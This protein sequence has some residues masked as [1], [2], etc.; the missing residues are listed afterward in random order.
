MKKLI[1]FFAAVLLCQAL[2]AQNEIVTT[3]APKGRFFPSSGLSYLDDPARYFSIQMINTTGT[4]MDIFFTIDLS[5]DFSINNENYYLRT[6]KEIQPASPLAVGASPVLINRTIFDQIIG[7]LNSSAY[8]TNYDLNNPS[9]NMLT[10]P[11][12]QYRFC[13]TPY[14][15]DG[16]NN[17]NPTKVGETVCYTFYICYTGSA[18]EFTTPVNGLSAGNFNNSNPTNNLLNQNAN[19]ALPTSDNRQ[20]SQYARLPLTRTVVFNWTGVISNCLT[21]NDFDYNLKIVEVALNQNVQD[22]IN[23]NGTLNTVTIK[24]KTNYIHDTVANRNFRFIPGHV[25]A[26]QVQ[27]VPKK[28]LVTDIQLSNEGKSQIITFVWGDNVPITQP[29]SSGS[30]LT[31]SDADNKDQVLKNIRNPYFL[32]P[33][34]DKAAIENLTSLIS[35]ESANIPA[36]NGNAYVTNVT[37]NDVPYYQVKKADSLTVNWMPVRGDSVIRVQYTAELYEYSGGP[38]SENLIG[39]PLKTKSFEVTTPTSF[40]PQ[41]TTPTSIATKDWAD[42]LEEGFKYLIHLKAKTDYSYAKTTTFTFTEYIHDMPVTHDSVTSTVMFGN[43]EYTSDVVFAWGI[44]SGALDKVYPPQFSYPVDLTTKPWNDSVWSDLPEVVKHEDFSFKWKAAKGVNYGDSVY[45]KLLVAKLPVGKKPQMVKD[46][47]FF[48]DSI[49]DLTYI[50]STLFDSLKTGGQYMAVLWAYVKQIGDT[51]SHYNILNGGKSLYA[52]FKLKDPAKF[53]ADLSNKIKCSPKALE[54]LSKDVITPK[55]D[56]LIQNQTRLKM[57]DFPLVIQTGKF[58][59]QK[60]TYTGDGYVVWKPFGIDVRLKV[61]FDSIQINKNN[62]IIK[63]TAAST[64]TDSSTYLSA[65]VN[66]LNLDEWTND[67]VTRA[68]G[69]L[70]EIDAVK[71]YYDKF[72]EYGEKYAKKYGGLLGPLMGGNI[73]TEVLTFPLSITDE[74]LTGSKNVIFAINNMFFSPETALMGLWAI[75]AAQDDDYYVPFLANNICMDQEGFLGKSSQHI[76]MFMG[77]T[78]EKELNDGYVLRFKASSNFADPKDGTVI[79]IDDGKLNYIRAEIQMDM[80]NDDLLGID[81]KTGTPQKGKIVQ[82]TLDVKFSDWSDWVVKVN[83]DPFAVTGSDRYVFVPTGKG[84]YYD[85]SA[86]ETP[87]VVTLPYEY[88]FGTPPPADLKDE[89]KK[90]L[91]KATKEWQGF[92]WDELSVVL[93]DEISNTF[94][95]NDTIK[96]DS[97][98]V[99]RYGINNTVVDSV[100]FSFPGRRISFGAK[101]VIIDKF[102]FSA[103]IYAHDLLRAETTKG[104]GWAFSLDTINVRFTKNK[105]KEGLIKGGFGVPLFSGGFKYSCSIGSDSLMFGISASKNPLDL[106][107]WAATVKFDSASSYFRI[108]KKYNESGTRIDL[109]MNGKISISGSKI[110]L[111]DFNAVKFE[112]MGMRNYNLSGKPKEGT[113]SIKGFEFDIGHW[114]FASPQKYIGGSHA[115]EQATADGEKPIGSVSIAG[116]TFSVTKFD[117]INES[118]GD[119]LK[120]GLTVKGKMK[121]GGDGGNEESA[122]GAG[123]GFSF[124]GVVQP[125]NK[126][127]VKEVKGKLESIELEDID[128][129]VFKMSGK[130]DFTYACPTCTDVT[131]FAGDLSIKVMSVVELSMRAGFGKEKSGNSEYSW[132][133]FDGACK[134]TPGIPLGAVSIN[135]F[136]GGFAWNMKAKKDLSDASYSAKALLTKAESNTD[137]ETTK[138]SGMDFTPAKNNWV[139]NAGISM[140]LTGAENT[141]NLDG[142]VSLRIGNGHFSGLF[143]EANAYVLTKVVPG[144]VPG[145]DSHNNKPLIKATTILGYERD[146]ERDYFR[147]SIAALA[148]MDLSKLLDGLSTSAVSEKIVGAIHSGTSL[149]PNSNIES[150]VKKLLD[151]SVNKDMEA[152]KSSSTPG[153]GMKVLIP[154]DFELTH[155]KKAKDGHKAGSTAWYFSIGKPDYDDRLLVEQKLDAVVFKS[156]SKFTFY[157]MTGNSF[158]FKFPELTPEL[159]TFFYGSQKDKKM[160]AS[161]SE[162]TSSRTLSMTDKLAVQNGGGFCMGA[163]FHA[164]TGFNCFLYADVTTDLGFDVALLNVGGVGCPGH[165]QIGK[166]NYYAIGQAYAALQGDV[167]LSLNLG[168]WKGKIS[169]FKAGVGA[170]L[171]AGGPNPSYCYGLLRFQVSMLNGLVKFNTSVDISLGDV[172]VPGAGDPLANVKLFQNVTPG[173]STESIAN[174]KSNIQ[175]P[176]QI[177]I[178]VS[179]MPWDRDVYL[180]DKD[181]KNGRTFRFV[182]VESNCHYYTKPN[183]SYIETQGTEKITFS[184]SRSD[185]NAIL[186]ETDEGGFVESTSNKLVLQARAFERRTPLYSTS[187]KPITFSNGQGKDVSYNVTGNEKGTILSKTP[188]SGKYGWFDPWWEDDNGKITVKRYKV[189]TTLYFKT[190]ALGYSLD[191]GVVFSWPYNGEKQFFCKEYVHSSGSS[192]TPYANMYLYKN[193]DNVFDKTKLGNAGKEMKIFLLRVGEEDNDVD[194]CAYSYSTSGSLPLVKVTLPKKEYT[195]GVGPRKLRFYIVDKNKYKAAQAA[196]EQSMSITQKNAEVQSRISN[197]TYTQAENAHKKNQ[198][199]NTIN[200]QNQQLEEIYDSKHSDGKDSMTF[201]RIKMKSDYKICANNG[202][203]VYEWTW[204]VNGNDDCNGD[205]IRRHFSSSGKNTDNSINYLGEAMRGTKQSPYSD[206]MKLSRQK[207]ANSNSPM[208]FHGWVFNYY[209]PDD[210][211]RYHSGCKLPPLAY[212]V[213]NRDANTPL[214]QLHKRY[215]QHFV[216]M[217]SDFKK[218]PLK[219]TRYCNSSG[220]YKY[221]SKGT[222]TVSDYGL[223]TELSNILKAGLYKNTNTYFD[224]IDRRIKGGTD[225]TQCTKAGYEPTSWDVPCILGI[226][227]GGSRKPMED[228]WFGGE[229]AGR[230]ML[231]RDEYYGWVIYDYASHAI[232]HDIRMIHDFMQSNQ[233]HAEAFNCRGW[234]HKVDFFKKYYSSSGK[235]LKFVY[236]NAANVAFP[237]DMPEI[238]LVTHYMWALDDLKGEKSYSTANGTTLTLYDKNHEFINVSDLQQKDRYWAKYWWNSAGQCLDY[239]DNGFDRDFYWDTKDKYYNVK[240][241]QANKGKQSVSVSNSSIWGDWYTTDWSNKFGKNITNYFHVYYISSQS[242]NFE[243]NLMKIAVAVKKGSSGADNTLIFYPNAII[244][245]DKCYYNIPNKNDNTPVPGTISTCG[246][247]YPGKPNGNTYGLR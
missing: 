192:P 149:I 247:L 121:F 234:S 48:K 5:C 144:S 62:E 239:S 157:L 37:G 83:M 153:F 235:N 112:H 15:W 195:S 242:S 64:A 236:G 122:F 225:F 66:D 126:Y 74:E 204:F 103:D 193:R 166:H 70:G 194:E 150:K 222:T 92:Y 172:C 125:K 143:V 12:G 40:S 163:T 165:P 136:S 113:A 137:Q 91:G 237:Y 186:F 184:G 57:G 2:W 199:S 86:K 124:W 146:K 27:A 185:E 50:D 110:G 41:N 44:D 61:H 55:V 135:G 99:Y 138:S 20:S 101:G 88:L 111:S 168:F 25:Y 17:P 52:T 182:L 223:R 23:Q 191:D 224:F 142:L 38:V 89:D 33:G 16:Y 19:G 8:E 227:Y 207:D 215:F 208:D 71:G 220:K 119:D 116:F 76:D 93:S 106:D 3:I 188:T 164:E 115:D 205:Y 158:S 24:G 174:S 58:D 120:L 190:K 147:L 63:G 206:F 219:T 82:A 14:R 42:T 152:A 100:H 210:S 69:Y 228:K 75:F 214:L 30:S 177:G 87:P 139:A 131:G 104:W 72:K 129:H 200:I 73:A 68:M 198:N 36:D 67:D 46:T 81:A 32:N 7:H 202:E 118:I 211:K 34:K 56:E 229:Y 97:M 107:L 155:Y 183:K 53:E 156:N 181:G 233:M 187:K 108:H 43:Q 148:D 45:Y 11:E 1:S 175:S 179:N 18:P 161:K 26:A 203:L 170:L 231:S 60:K 79:S 21:V 90:K 221:D 98:V 31:S 94:L 51:S 201:Y 178:I 173:F 77:R 232:V 209:E 130:L 169:L 171:Q 160:D 189:D 47:L 80:S 244:K 105:Y 127:K 243:N 117:F 196:A 140:I 141:M 246:K 154:V 65:L 85:H 123:T 133:F 84:I 212:I 180:V 240:S 95:S 159:Q 22:A 218:T 213:L 176:L 28:N 245:T 59:E 151:G 167:G 6:K 96:K 13:I 217:Q 226:F 162:I 145:D 54:S 230:W 10:L 114:S 39:Q 197:S 134:F 109:N 29:E 128:F 238:Y 78:Y 216:D 49:T 35:S 4:S 132:W 102:G 9:L 241:N